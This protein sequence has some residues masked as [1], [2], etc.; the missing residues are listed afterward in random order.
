MP[1]QALLFLMPLIIAYELALP[2]W[3]VTDSGIQREIAARQ[4]L[5]D[6]FDRLGI[7]GEHLP[8]F[9]III[10]L[11]VLHIYKRDPWRFEPKLY[12]AMWFESLLLALPLFVFGM[13]WYRYAQS[14]NLFTTYA[15]LGDSI[16]GLL[17]AGGSGETWQSQMLFAVGAG[18][19]EEL[20]FRLACIV[21]LHL[22]LVDVI[23]LK[24]PMGSGI[25]VVVAAV[26]FALYHF[27]DSFPFHVVHFI[28]F[29]A[30][31]IYLG[32]IFLL[33]GFGI[34]A[35]VHALYDIMIVALYYT[36]RQ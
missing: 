31:G 7:G 1:L 25:A 26:A 36:P 2:V 35:A 14:A 30:A 29:T 5:F 8:M 15:W 21:L 24:E 3:G 32:A 22:V 16:T 13:M 23:E 12:L 18:L 11:L 20:F 4:M 10:I 28:F 34:V 9:I 27:S 17:A 33:R 6:F 19:Y